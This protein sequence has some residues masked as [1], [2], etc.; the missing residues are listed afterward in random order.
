M[1]NLA[2]FSANSKFPIFNLR[3]IKIFFQEPRAWKTTSHATV[4]FIVHIS[5]LSTTIEGLCMI[6]QINSSIPHFS[7]L[8]SRSFDKNSRNHHRQPSLLNFPTRPSHEAIAR[9]SSSYKVSSVP[10]R[11]RGRIELVGNHP[12]HYL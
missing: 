4:T 2:S 7:Y 9:P 5:K 3:V 8:P 10:H 11:P 1:Q 12:Y 6:Y